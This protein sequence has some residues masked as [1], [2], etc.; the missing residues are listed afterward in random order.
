MVR[1]GHFPVDRSRDGRLLASLKHGVACVKA[2]N[3]DVAGH[4]RDHV[5]LAFP[6]LMTSTPQHCVAM[7]AT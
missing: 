3:I 6:R 4:S 7:S 5:R 2:T 1:Q